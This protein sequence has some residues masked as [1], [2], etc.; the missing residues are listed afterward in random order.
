MTGGEGEGDSAEAATSRAI[1]ESVRVGRWG[2]PADVGELVAFLV[3]DRAGFISGG[4]VTIA[5]GS[6][7][8]IF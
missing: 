1:R 7:L 4:T 8:R 5:G 6:D 2:R 3:S